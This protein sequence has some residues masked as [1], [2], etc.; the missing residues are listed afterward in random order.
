METAV[1]ILVRILGA[2]IVIG[3]LWSAMLTVVVPR[4]ERPRI[5]RYHFKLTGFF[6]RL[7]HR[8]IHNPERRDLFDSRLAP[9]GLLSLAFVWAFHIVIGFAAIFWAQGVRGFSQALLLSG[10]SLTTLGI[11]DADSTSTLIIVVI[12]GLI[13][14]GLVGLMISYL[15]TVYDAYLA[16]EVAVA[17]LEVRAGRPPHPFTLLH[18]V[19]L[20]GWLDSNM[21]EFWA[22]WENWFLHIEE[23]HTTHTSL[24][25]FR[26]AHYRR[27]WL[28]VAGVVLDTA[29]LMDSTL[30]IERSPRAALCIRSGFN[31]LGSIADNFEIARPSAPS[32]SDSVTISRRQFDDLWVE[33]E[34]EGLPLKPDRDQAWED[35]T[36]WRVNYDAAIYGLFDYLRIEPGPWFGGYLARAPHGVPGHRL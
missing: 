28:Q 25:F 24:S 27:S 30:A 6:S 14:L 12:E 15:P 22:E 16:R 26:S 18:R 2:L 21:D 17:R 7:A 33:L 35:F 34:A 19:H 29:A 8:W 10:S 9:F 4:A 13:G 5:T 31:A 20:V 1:E 36:G 23:T 32:S 3:T 11:R